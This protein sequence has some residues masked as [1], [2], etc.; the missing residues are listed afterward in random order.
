MRFILLVFSILSFFAVAL[1]DSRVPFELPKQSELR[2][3][4]SALLKTSKG[5]IYIELYPDKAPWHVAN[6]KFLAEQN[7]YDG[8]V[9]HLVMDGYIAQGGTPAGSPNYG[10]RYDLPPEFNRLKHVEGSLGMARLPDDIN[11]E[12]RSHGAQFHLLMREAP[13]LDGNYTVF[14]QVVRGLDVIFNLEK[15]DEIIDLEVYVRK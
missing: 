6:F 4:R 11:P 13:K 15:G 8:K 14:G 1:A 12:R 5:D 10:P 3:I 7:Y 9:F 2:K